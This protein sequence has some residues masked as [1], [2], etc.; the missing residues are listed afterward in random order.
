MTLSGGFI[1]KPS[2]KLELVLGGIP[3][4]LKNDGVNVSWDDDIPK[5]WKNKKNVP[6]HQPELETTPLRI[7]RMI[8]ISKGIRKGMEHLKTFFGYVGEVESS[9]IKGHPAG[10]FPS[11]LTENTKGDPQR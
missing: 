11:F 8:I 4:S 1:R 10:L 6:N 9:F 7:M 3:T 2:G 5:I